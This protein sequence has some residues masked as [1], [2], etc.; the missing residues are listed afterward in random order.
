MGRSSDRQVSGAAICR[1]LATLALTIP[2]L[3]TGQPESSSA[4]ALDKR[5]VVVV[6]NGASAVSRAAAL[7]YS[8]SRQLSPEMLLELT[9]PLADPMLGDPADEEVTRPEY[10]ALIRDPVAAYLAGLGEDAP[11]T[12]VTVMGVPLRIADTSGS[13]AILIDSTAA[14]VDAELA[15][16]GSPLE[17][18]PGV[19]VSTNPYFGVGTDFSTWKA[20]H[21]DAPLRYLVTR[22]A[23]YQTPRDQ[24]DLPDSIRSLVDRAQ[25]AAD[26]NA[27]WVVDEDATGTPLREPA[28]QHI[29][30]PATGLLRFLRLNVVHD[31]STDVLH[32]LAS[33][34][35][36]A[37]WGSNDTNAPAPPY[38][39]DIEGIVYPGQFAPRAIVSTIVSTNARSF[40]AP[41]V[42]GQSLIAD[43][44][45]LGV[46][47]TAGNVYEPGAFQ[48]SYPQALFARYAAGATAAEAYYSSLPYLGWMNLFVGDPLMRLV[49]PDSDSDGASDRIDSCDL[50][51]IGAAVDSSGCSLPQFCSGFDPIDDNEPLIMACLGADWLGDEPSSHEPK[52]C[53]D[54]KD[55]DKIIRCEPRGAGN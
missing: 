28:D 17:G 44:V 34:V 1:F 25:E 41:P 37:S 42:Y 6:F 45:E 2:V 7:Y 31:T 43:F 5:D 38:Y 9:I 27:L 35:A 16:L 51:P 13:D 12:I 22:I 50:T 48:I 11:D 33:I 19:L 3:L 14:S 32:D 21:P 40:V 23:G 30:R 4:Q 10:N 49:D 29:L 39:G 46:A 54:E 55:D 24:F 52:D 47:G 18:S 26:P 8:F 15:V 53:K 36:F 20:A